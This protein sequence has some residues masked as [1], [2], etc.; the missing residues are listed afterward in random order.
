[1]QR[2]QVCDKGYVPGVSTRQEIWEDSTESF[3]YMLDE[4]KFACVFIA[5]P[6]H[7]DSLMIFLFKIG[8]D[9]IK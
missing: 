8:S 4:V 7:F 1:M 9:Y 2:K 3:I 5:C 6:L